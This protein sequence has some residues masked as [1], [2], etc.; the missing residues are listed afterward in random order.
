MMNRR[1]VNIGRFNNINQF[2][3]NEYT[4][5]LLLGLLFFGA[6][7]TWGVEVLVKMLFSLS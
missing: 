1:T 3:L 5:S 4:G 7:V 2:I 6:F